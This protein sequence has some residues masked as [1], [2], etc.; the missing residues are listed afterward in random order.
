MDYKSALLSDP[1]ARPVPVVKLE[2]TRPYFRHLRI[3]MDASICVEPWQC[4]TPLPFTRFED[5]EMRNN[6]DVFVVRIDIGSRYSTIRRMKMGE[7]YF[8]GV[9][10]ALLCD[11]V[12]PS[13][14]DWTPLRKCEFSGEI[15]I[16]QSDAMAALLAYDYAKM[17][18]AM[19]P[20]RRDLLATVMHPTRLSH[21]D[22]L[23]L[24]C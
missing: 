23:Q 3:C 17:T 18:Q 24:M 21:L 22:G 12:T 5:K 4:S 16:S 13:K 14:L 15:F 20:L 9:A 2:P 1:K 10:F 11:F 8:S 19:A 6:A 7:H